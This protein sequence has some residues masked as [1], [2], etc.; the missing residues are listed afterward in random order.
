MHAHVSINL[1]ILATAFD[2]RGAFHRQ[3]I[4]WKILFFVKNL[5][6]LM[7][8]FWKWKAGKF[9]FIQKLYSNAVYKVPKVWFEFLNSIFHKHL[10]YNL[11][12]GPLLGTFE[13]SHVQIHWGSC[14]KS[15]VLNIQKGN[16]GQWNVP[17]SFFESTFSWKNKLWKNLFKKFEGGKIQ[18]WQKDSFFMKKDWFV[19]NL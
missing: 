12:I 15:V 18:T 9:R 16:I 13:I 19:M 6:F 10:S 8:I 17:S 3:K 1:N 4:L 14:P 2:S 11:L 7:D 5:M